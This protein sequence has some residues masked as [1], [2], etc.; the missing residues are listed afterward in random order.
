LVVSKDDMIDWCFSSFAGNRPAELLGMKVLI[1]DY[2]DA[3]EIDL[4]QD[5]LA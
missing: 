3:G 5:V 1:G 4:A 2:L